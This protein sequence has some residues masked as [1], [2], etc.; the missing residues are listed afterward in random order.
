MNIKLSI[1]DQCITSNAILLWTPSLFGT[2]QICKTLYKSLEGI[3]N[4]RINRLHVRSSKHRLKSVYMNVCRVSRNNDARLILFLSAC[5]Y[6]CI[7]CKYSRGRETRNCRDYLPSFVGTCL[8]YIY[9]I[10]ISRCWYLPCIKTS[11]FLSEMRIYLSY[12]LPD[13]FYM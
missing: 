8:H 12:I 2:S 11:V 1:H 13:R 7:N 9:W 6:Y 4:V 10:V 5:L 3:Y